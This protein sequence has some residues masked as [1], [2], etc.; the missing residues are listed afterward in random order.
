V[1]ANELEDNTN[2]QNK[3]ARKL[4]VKTDQQPECW[5]RF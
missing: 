1:N 5:Y 2:V 4:V 3:S